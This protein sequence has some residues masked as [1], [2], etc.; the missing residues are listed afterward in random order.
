MST[1]STSDAAFVAREEYERVVAQRDGLLDRL[2]ADP[3]RSGIAA[4]DGL[5]KMLPEL[6]IEE[7]EACH[8]I[9]DWIGVARD[10]LTLAERVRLLALE[11][12]TKQGY[13]L[14]EAEHLAPS[15]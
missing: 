9:L 12:A 4:L 2:L 13:S 10:D 1:H 11:H 5:R 3:E 6:K 8:A 7:D 15:A 14:E